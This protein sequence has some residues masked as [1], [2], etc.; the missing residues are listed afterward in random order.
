MAGEATLYAR[1]ELRL[2]DA[3][4]KLAK[5]QGSVDKNMANVERRTKKAAASMESSLA[6]SAAKI[7][8]VFKSFGAGLVAGVAAGG[9]TGLVTGFREIASGIAEISAEA[10]RAGLSNKAFQ[11]LKFA[12]EQSRVSVDALTDG[13]KELSLRTDEFIIS[14]GKSGSAAEA[15]QRL[16][17][18]VDELKTK[19]KDPSALLTEIIGKVQRLDKAAQVRIFDELFGGTG[20]EQ[21]VRFIERG[22]SG[23]RDSIKA[24]NDLGIV[25]NDEVIAKAAEVDR[26]FNLIA[27]TIGGNL[28][29]AIVDAFSAL[30]AF[31]DQYRD[32]TNQMNSTIDN[33]VAEL[34]TKR[35]EIET[36][37]LETQ[38]KQRQGIE[39][40]SDVAKRN[41]FENSKNPLLAGDT[42]QIENYRKQLADLAAEEKA[43]VD[44]RNK[45]VNLNPVTVPAPGAAGGGYSGGS[46]VPSS[47][48]GGG[49]R[50]GG[51][52]SSADAFQR[53]VETLRQHTD[54]LKS[55][56][57]AQAGLNPLVNDY[58][59]ALAKAQANQDLLTAAQEAGLTVT[60]ALKAT[61]DELAGAYATASVESD[62]LAEQQDRI[63]ETAEEWN[64]TARD[65]TSGF[66][67]DLRSGTSAAESLANAL[68]KVVDKLID[69]GLN[70]IF[71]SS[72]GGIG[73]FLGSIFGFA[74]GGVA[75][76][77]RPQPLKTFARGGVSR[78]AAIF[79]E[80]GPEAAVPLPDGRN[81]P[82]KL[83]EPRIP[84]KA[85]RSNDVVTIT[86]KDDSGRMADI[87]DQRIQTASGT[88]VKVAVS[89]SNR[90]VMPTVAKFQSQKA[91][92]DWR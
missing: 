88:I 70:S 19:I 10:Q 43:L 33:R 6:A 56:T 76:R 18:S 86:L 29:A 87:A 52:G 22:E 7:G 90:Q 55:E 28:K 24:A 46:A 34:G 45:R 71:S 30:A 81:I 89:E 53:A 77:G 8:G 91:G 5:F 92:A 47:S 44:E 62:R 23:I 13:M 16:G 67:S 83:M 26:Q 27:S 78:T 51:G 1:M 25:I 79:G 72:G 74:D 59:F 40:L 48:G 54:A 37:I 36:K 9:I 75:A 42:G 60:P 32:V 35:L 12:A 50:G 64:S 63:R 80:A 2:S 85:A 73:G 41:G 61:I 20:G 49:S 69:V 39:Q 84:S 17:Y 31:V 3:E 57:A 68:N 38:D 4:K 15:F 21:F 82:V 11:E 58:G 66:I 65:V 14:G